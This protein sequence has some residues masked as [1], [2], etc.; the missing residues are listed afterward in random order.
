MRE[1]VTQ[2]EGASGLAPEACRRVRFSSQCS[3]N[4]IATDAFLS[5][6]GGGHTRALS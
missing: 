5:G 2:G 4:S 1:S 6:R 3:N